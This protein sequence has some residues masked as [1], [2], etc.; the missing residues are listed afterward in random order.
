MKRKKQSDAEDY[1]SFVNEESTASEK[2]VSYGRPKLVPTLTADNM[3]WS[4]TSQRGQRDLLEWL[5][6]VFKP[7]HPLND[8]WRNKAGRRL[9]RVIAE[10]FER[11]PRCLYS[12]CEYVSKNKHPSKAWQAA[13]WNE[14]M[15]RLGY[16]IATS[17]C[18][19]PGT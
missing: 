15:R 4:Y 10:R 14:T 11:R 9:V 3:S 6:Y 17:A 18:A 16:E 12:F 5:D 2:K 19:D 8:R 13:C 1:F 7:G